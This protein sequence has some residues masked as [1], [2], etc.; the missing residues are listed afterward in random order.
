MSVGFRPNTTKTL[1]VRGP[2]LQNPSTYRCIKHGRMWFGWNGEIVA[3]EAKIVLACVAH[4]NFSLVTMPI[5][6]RDY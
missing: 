4:D 1:G 3:D 2:E 6:E 5:T